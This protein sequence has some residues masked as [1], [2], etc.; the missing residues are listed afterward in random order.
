MQDKKIDA[1]KQIKKPNSIIQATA[2]KDMKAGQK[3]LSKKISTITDPIGAATDKISGKMS[4]A[5]AFATTM[6]ANVAVGL[7][8]QAINYHINNIGRET[9]DSNYQAQINRQME[10]TNDFLNAGQGVLTGA[11]SGAAVGGPVGAVIGGAIGAISSAINIGFRQAERER[12]YQHT[13]FK[14]ANSQAVQLARANYSW[15]TGRVR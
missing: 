14:E 7:V 9:G 13:I 4:P 11:A 8:K 3:A 5:G 1:S 10:I 15:N 6:G 12:D 2:D